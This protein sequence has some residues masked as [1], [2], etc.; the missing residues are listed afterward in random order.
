MADT[1]PPAKR[2]R[3]SAADRISIVGL[4]RLGLCQALTLER[5]GFDVLGCDVFPPYVDSINAKTLRSD[6]PG[7]VDALLAST[8]LRA[9]LSL[10]A[11]V[12]FSDLIMVVVATPTGIGEHAY[13][14]GT[15]SR[16]LEDIGKLGRPNKH[17]VVC[18]TVLP[19]YIATVATTLLEGCDG[20]T[21]SYNPEFIAQGDIM[22]GLARP[23]IVLI[24]EGS[25]AAGDR[26][27]AVHERASA[28]APRVCRMSAA[29][30]EIAK[31]ALNCFVTTKI[32]YANMVGDIADRTPG[33]DKDAILQA[34][35][36]DRRV[37]HECLKAGFGFG[38]PCFPRDNRALG[39]YARQRGVEPTLCDATDEFNRRHAQAM[40]DVLLQ[41]GLA[42]YTLSDVAFKPGCPVAIIEESQP[43]EVAKRLVRAGKT[44]TI[45][46]RAFIIS[47]VRRTYGKLFEYETV[48]EDDGR[49]PNVTMDNPQSSYS[50]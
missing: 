24:G 16:V 23:D 40:A 8:R 48:D 10:E 39:T 21:V 17:V 42:R 35:G 34:V 45:R 38:G 47:L 11:A 5:A 44:V 28:N 43:L 26:L 3:A 50:R 27:Q 25:T 46:D 4:G 13:D 15:L 14:C 41:Q 37:G 6:E 29:S 9:T 1:Q 20:A 32:S 12:D 30:A 19:G 31:L 22:A 7:V 33:A 2:Q 36:A 18:C 49:E